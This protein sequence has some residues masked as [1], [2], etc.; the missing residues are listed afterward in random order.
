MSRLEKIIFV[1]DMAEEGRRFEG[2]LPLR[3][4]AL[5][6]LDKAVYMCAGATIR[7]N[8][9]KGNPVHKNAYAVRDCFK[10]LCCE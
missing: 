3:K 4:A 6:N 9:G 10:K 2:A 7:F 5:Q 1:A 8:E